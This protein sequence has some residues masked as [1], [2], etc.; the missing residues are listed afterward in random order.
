VHTRDELATLAGLANA[1]GVTV[2][3]DE[4]HAPLV[5][6]S[7]TF[8]PYL[9]VGGAEHGIVVTS[10][11]KSWNL[12]GLKAAV[13]VPGH[14]ARSAVARLHQFVT[15]GASHLGAIAHIA[16]WTHGVGWLE[17]VRGEL[18][19][20]RQLLSELVAD[21]LP[22]VRFKPPAAT[23]LGWLDCS[24][25]G[26]GDDPAVHFREQGRVALSAGPE[27]G[28]GGRGCVR[29]NFGTSPQIL[30]EAVERMARSLE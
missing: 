20:N 23:Y 12:A 15:F 22:G 1:H 29:L 27:F 10:A 9:T 13:I 2:I 28:A 16:A 11:S 6:A 21:R 8:T 24:E 14:E 30:R 18:D 7:S 25:L 5:Y 17:A 19:T 4:I 3:S 26:L